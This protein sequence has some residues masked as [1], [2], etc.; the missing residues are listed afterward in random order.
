MLD[1][2][3]LYRVGEIQREYL[4]YMV[5]EKLPLGLTKDISYS[6]KGEYDIFE[7]D[8]FNVKA[9]FPDKRTQNI[10][11]KWGGRTLNI[12]GTDESTKSNSFEFLQDEY[13]KCYDI[14]YDCQQLTGSTIKNGDGLTSVGQ[15]GTRV[16]YPENEQVFDV[17]IAQVSVSKSIVTDY[18]RLINAKVIGVKKSNLNKEGNGLSRITCDLVW[19]DSVIDRSKRFKPLIW[20]II[21]LGIQKTDDVLE[22]VIGVNR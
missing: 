16:S 17:R 11:L 19:E 1:V 5:I 13:G 8:K 10:P 18:A 14:L 2:F 9:I 15:F 3:D 20:N 4:Y 22:H 21:R 6:S 12:S 7:L